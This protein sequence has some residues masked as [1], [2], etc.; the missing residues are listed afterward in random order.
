MIFEIVDDL[1]FDSLEWSDVPFA[2]P[3]SACNIYVIVFVARTIL[4]IDDAFFPFPKKSVK[5]SIL[6]MSDLRCFASGF[7]LYENV[8]AIVDRLQKSDQFAAWREVISSGLGIAEK[9][10]KRN[11]SGN[12]FFC[13]RRGNNQ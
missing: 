11:F 13:W 6:Y 9:I 7:L 10:L 3:I 1:R 8:Q 4:Q 5:I 12:A 2:A